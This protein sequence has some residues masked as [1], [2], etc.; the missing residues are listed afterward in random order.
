MDT[1]T[2][3][4]HRRALGYEAV[5]P[6]QIPFIREVNRIKRVEFCQKLLDTRDTFDDV[7]FTDESSIQIGRNSHIAIA[8]IERDA[9]GRTISKDKPQ[10]EA[11]KHPVKVHVWGGISRNGA[12]KLK[13]FDGIMCADF[14]T[15]EILGNTL[16]PSIYHLYPSPASHR[17]WQDN[18]PKHTS[19]MAK[20]FIEENQINWFKTPAESPDL[21]VI[22]NVWAALKKHVGKENPRT[23]DAL[24]VSVIK[25]WESHL[26]KDQCNRY[27]NHIYQV[28]PKVIEVN[29]A[30]SGF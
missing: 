20:T 13:V 27:I 19:K 9:K 12:T 21:N 1:S 18:D 17:L 3:R 10:F 6:V 2:I 14:Y 22:E 4:K 7:I 11:L 23:R 16:L 26:T 29:G 28:M 24:A 15:N 30:H 25:F 5:R 8:K